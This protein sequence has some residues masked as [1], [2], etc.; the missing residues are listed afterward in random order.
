MSDTSLR[1]IA[2]SLGSDNVGGMAQKV[3][4]KWPPPP[5]VSVRSLAALATQNIIVAH[6]RLLDQNLNADQRISVNSYNFT[7]SGSLS[8][9]SMRFITTLEGTGSAT[10]PGLTIFQG[11]LFMAY[12][13]ILG[14]E[15]IWV[16]SSA[17]GINWDPHQSINGIGSL[18]GPSLA[19]FKGQLYMIYRG[20]EEDEQIYW[21]RSSDGVHWNPNPPDPNPQRQLGGTT[22]SVPQLVA[23]GDKLLAIWRGIIGDQELWFSINRGG[24]EWDTPQTIPNKGS[25]LGVGLAVFQGQVIMAY[26]GIDD[27]QTIYWA[28]SDDGENWSDQ[29]PIVG[30]GTYN[31]PT[32]TT[33]RNRLYMI[34]SGIKNDESVY[35][36]WKTADSDWQPQQ[37]IPDTVNGGSILSAVTF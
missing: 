27:D 8:Q 22:A 12:R 21:T 24:T 30:I 33:W 32:L 20:V 14:D 7:D 9:Q 11:R 26:P 19:T 5:P 35:W 29:R 36:T 10:G 2:Q 28:H 34:Y 25:N 31:P 1:Q 37:R 3:G 13:G 15:G 16:S 18:E 6:R 17:D 4:L 23:F